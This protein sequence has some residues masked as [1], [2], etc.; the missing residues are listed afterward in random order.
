VRR[1]LEAAYHYKNL[2]STIKILVTIDF[3]RWWER[4][5]QRTNLTVSVLG[6]FSKNADQGVRRCIAKGAAMANNAASASNPQLESVGTGA[7]GVTGMA[8]AGPVAVL[9]AVS[10][11]SLMHE[12][13]V[14]AGAAVTV[15]Q[16]EF[17]I[18]VSAG[19]KN[20]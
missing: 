11:T 5:Q 15:A 4:S 12:S 13:G 10:R 2:T 9:V 6:Y 18:A 8:G 16:L 14:P 1:H 17:L 3:D 19:A 20:M 7:G